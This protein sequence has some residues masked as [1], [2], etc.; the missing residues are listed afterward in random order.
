MTRE[1]LSTLVEEMDIEIQSRRKGDPAELIADNQKIK[2]ELKNSGNIIE[3]FVYLPIYPYVH[4][5]YSLKGMDLDLL[6]PYTNDR[7]A[8]KALEEVRQDNIDA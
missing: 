4:V 6:T 3:D 7:K 2:S 8:K 1:E 5:P